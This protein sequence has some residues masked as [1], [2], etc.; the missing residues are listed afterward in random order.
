M[1][2]AARKASEMHTR[3]AA[4]IDAGNQREASLILAEIERM[5]ERSASAGA[6]AKAARLKRKT[7]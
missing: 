7:A 2:E 1:G 3:L 4:A 5:R 6:V